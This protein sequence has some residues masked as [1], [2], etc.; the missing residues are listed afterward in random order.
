MTTES[1]YLDP[2][3]LLFRM[4]ATKGVCVN[5]ASHLDARYGGIATSLPEF[6]RAT[7]GEWNSHLLGVCGHEETASQGPGYQLTRLPSGRL[8]WAF[9]R[10]LRRSLEDTIARADIVHIHGIWQEHC[11][12][13]CAAARRS[14]RP[15]VV[16]AHGMLDSWALRQKSWRKAPY[17]ALYER[18]N[19]ASAACLR[20]LTRH[21]V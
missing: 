9:N 12:H 8:R 13:A 2:D 16:S 4:P 20:A 6:C 17:L 21:E 3:T 15:Y 14:L 5:V 1:P 10:E 11:M 7:S 18:R 19:L